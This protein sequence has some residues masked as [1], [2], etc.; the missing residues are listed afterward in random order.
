MTT[1][2]LAGGDYRLLL[3]CRL[4]NEWIGFPLEVLPDANFATDPSPADGATGVDR[5][6]LLSWEPGKYAA[7]TGGHELY[8]STDFDDVNERKGDPVVLDDPYYA[9]PSPNAPYDSLDVIYW[10][11]DEVNDAHPDQ[12]WPGDVWTF[13][14]KDYSVIDNFEAYTGTGKSKPPLQDS[15]KSVWV[16]G[17]YTFEP[18]GSTGTSGSLVQLN[19]DTND[20]QP[21]YAHYQPEDI[22][23]SGS[24]SM[25]FYYD[26]DGTVSW[27]SDL[28]GC[29]PPEACN[30]TP[31][32]NPYLSEAYAAI[33]D[34]AQED[35]ELDSLD[36]LR[37]W[38]GYKVLKISFYGDT[39]N[40]TNNA[41][42]YVSLQDGDGTLVT[43]SH[44]NP[45]LLTEPWWH[46]WYIKLSDFTD[47]NVD[48]ALGDI[49]KIYIGFGNKENPVAGGTGFVFFDDIELL[50]H[51]VCIHSSVTGDLDGDCTVDNS[52]LAMITKLWFGQMPTL[53]TPIIN[54]SA[55]SL[56]L[57]P[58]QNWTNTG[59]M[60]GM[61]T[62]VNLSDSNNPVVE[63]IAGKRCVTFDAT[64][65]LIWD[66]NAPAT[67]TGA[68]DF[69]VV[70]E[71]FNLEI[72]D[73]EWLLAWAERSGPDG[74]SASFG[75]GTN[76]NS[77]AAV[78]WGEPDMG[79]GPLG[80]PAEHTWHTIAVTYNGTT[81]SI[82]VDGLIYNV[83]D[84]DL[85]ITESQP[86]VIGAAYEPAVGGI[87]QGAWNPN[88]NLR[89]TG[90][91]ASI[92]VYAESIPPAELALWMGSPADLYHDNKIDLKDIAVLGNNWLIGPILFGEDY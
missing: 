29:D 57:G 7:E 4:R 56:P 84:K 50:A 24:Q 79:F 34:D 65:M 11:V 40:T 3:H 47:K 5:Y 58:L 54:L 87:I 77:S 64:D 86:V 38:S 53:P 41:G 55:A 44:S 63:T 26:N 12:K 35:P 39:N 42:L 6:P 25:K 73:E 60:G 8:Y 2:S 68:N 18:W 21:D 32:P 92:R 52:D 67:I 49:A 81:E 16:D 22:A 74:S 78:H 33:D 70:F 1:T 80:A 61:F 15:L 10:V 91:V 72:A 48:L 13:T 36:I 37:D 20:G 90:S 89:Y 27:E 75:Y 76:A 46:G 23:Q 62:D 83:E 17:N 9:I 59:S 82:V 85:I 43:I 19:T 14:I 51:G 31:S 45:T 30:Y 66:Y 88:W 71:V 28:Y 69:T